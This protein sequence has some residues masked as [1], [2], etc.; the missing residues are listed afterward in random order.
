[1]YQYIYI[2]YII[3]IYI[4]FI[5]IIY[6]HIYIYIILCVSSVHMYICILYVLTQTSLP[7]S[8]S[9]VTLGTPPS[10]QDVGWP[11]GSDSL[12]IV[13]WDQLGRI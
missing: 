12:T 9:V 6:I 7:D 13:N 11:S 10:L 4:L 1:M 5:H 2:Y 8:A 3:Y